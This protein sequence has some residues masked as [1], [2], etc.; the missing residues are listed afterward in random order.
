MRRRVFATAIPSVRY[1]VVGVCWAKCYSGAEEL[2]KYGADS[3]A[4]K[5]FAVSIR[6][7]VRVERSWSIRPAVWP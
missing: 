6:G 3:L 7:Q 5:F 1:I 2:S 4:C